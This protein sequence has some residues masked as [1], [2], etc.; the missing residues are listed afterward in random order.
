MPPPYGE[1][2]RRMIK[3]SYNVKLTESQRD[4]LIRYLSDCAQQTIKQQHQ[5][6]EANKFEEIYD[7]DTRNQLAS[8]TARLKWFNNI[9]NALQNAKKI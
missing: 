1:K 8:L 7:A 5:I 4:Q 6:H 3:P 2:G 9:I